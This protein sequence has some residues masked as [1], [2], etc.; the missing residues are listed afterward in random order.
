MST[1]IKKRAC[2]RCTK[3]FF[4]DGNTLC[5]ACDADVTSINGRTGLRDWPLFDR[6]T[7]YRREAQLKLAA[8]SAG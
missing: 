1:T 3:E 7:A 6:I 4:D 8:T 2:L 5:P